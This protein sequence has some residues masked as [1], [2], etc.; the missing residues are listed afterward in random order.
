LGQITNRLLIVENNQIR[1]FTGS[2]A[3]YQEEL[4]KN[5]EARLRKKEVVL[6][7]KEN[8]KKRLLNN[9]KESLVQKKPHETRF[10]IEVCHEWILVTR[11]TK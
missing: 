4:S 5:K 3:E 8:L 6:K 11:K 2:Y 1:S 10:L 9:N 7:E